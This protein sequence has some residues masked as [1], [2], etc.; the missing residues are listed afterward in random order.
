MITLN[1][2]L[3]LIP[4]TGLFNLDSDCF[5]QVVDSE[6]G[7]HYRTNPGEILLLGG[8][9]V[10]FKMSDLRKLEVACVEYVDDHCVISVKGR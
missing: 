9:P 4:Y 2:L 6:T 10:G 5:L 8:E 1:A 7:A 3:R